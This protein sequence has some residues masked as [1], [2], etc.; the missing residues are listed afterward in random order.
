MT[1]LLLIVGSLVAVFQGI[2]QGLGRFSPVGVSLLIYAAFRP[3]LVIPLLLLGFGVAGAMGATAI[4][5]A[6]AG[7]VVLRALGDVRQ[8]RAKAADAAAI[9][10]FGIVIAGLLAF[11]LLTNLDL[12]VAK[13]FLPKVEAGQYASAALVGKLAAF[14]PASAIS[15]VLLPRATERLRRGEDATGPLRKSLIVSVGFGLALTA[16][17]F[18]V[19][20]SAVE[21]VFGA[22]FGDAVDLLAPSAAA[23]TICGALNVHLAFAIAAGDRVFVWLLIASAALQ[24]VLFGFLHSSG[25]EIIAATALAAL[26]ALVIHEV[27]SPVAGWRLWRPQ[28]TPS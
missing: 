21:T 8:R 22:Q 4:A 19:P 1:A 5:Y 24:A 11:T 3:T 12:L 23:M 2:L 20:Q 27:R 13:A 17:L 16:L 9:E 26:P 28:R 14:L 10:R 6:V 15:P 18:A 25:Y 7:L